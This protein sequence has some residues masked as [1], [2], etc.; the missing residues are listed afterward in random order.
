VQPGIDLDARHGMQSHAT[1]IVQDGPNLNLL[2]VFDAIHRPDE[3]DDAEPSR[4]CQRHAIAV[5]L[6]TF[7]SDHPMA[8]RVAA[9]GIV[10][11]EMLVQAMIAPL[12]GYRRRYVLWSL[13]PVWGWVIGWRLGTRL[14]RLC[15]TGSSDVYEASIPAAH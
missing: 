12:V 10:A 13:L 9:A 11:S 8:I 1:C 6:A 4:V 5:A 7:G 3:R 14:S 2:A 15:R